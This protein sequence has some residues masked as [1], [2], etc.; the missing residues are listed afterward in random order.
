MKA[1]LDRPELLSRPSDPLTP[2]I[3]HEPWWLQAATGGRYDEVTVSSGGREV[4]RLPF[5]CRRHFGFVSCALP[6]LTHFLG[7]AVDEGTG[8]TV[9]RNLRR[10]Q[11]T[12]E[13][14]EKLPRF[15]NFY[16]LLHRGVPDALPFLQQGFDASPH[17]TFEIAPAPEA[18][19]WSN[20]RDKVRNVIRRAQEQ[21]EVFD[22]EPDTFYNFYTANLETRGQEH[23]YLFT[24]QAT[25]AFEA[26]VSRQRGRLLGA[27]GADGTVL[28]A[29][30][31]VWDDAVSYYMLATR[32][33]GSSNGIISRLIWEAIRSAAAGGRIF[34]FGGVG[35]L[36]NSVLFY[37]AFG[38]EV[39]PRYVV[40]RASPVYRSVREALAFSRGILPKLKGTPKQA[41]EQS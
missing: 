21:S 29:V 22:L 31:Y 13:L 24:S 35:V 20:M 6:Q 32:R 8:G 40:R 3:F 27:R 38:G 16:Q 25:A 5:V 14:I 19:L 37:T 41:G 17:F 28:G 36:G 9:S 39:R 18:T 1:K 7:P 2:T 30:F 23:N 12:R 11:I 4:G 26:A 34:D 15:D 10:H 33:P